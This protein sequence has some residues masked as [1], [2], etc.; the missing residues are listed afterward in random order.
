M[1]MFS[2]LYVWRSGRFAGGGAAGPPFRRC[3][4]QAS[5]TGA[6]S[7]DAAGGIR[8]LATANAVA[9]VKAVATMMAVALLGRGKRNSHGYIGRG[10]DTQLTQPAPLTT[11]RLALNPLHACSQIWSCLG[12]A[13]VGVVP[14]L[15]L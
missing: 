4:Q 13:L 14:R 2:P 15:S 8:A 11:L 5:T 3:A 6:S 10:Q 7:A 1:E 9:M 12:V